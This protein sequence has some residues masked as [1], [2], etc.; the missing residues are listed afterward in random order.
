[1]N[2]ILVFLAALILNIANYLPE[3]YPLTWLGMLPLIFVI[4]RLKNKAK[5]VGQ[6]KNKQLKNLDRNQNLPAYQDLPAFKLG[7]AF[8]FFMTAFSSIF[9]YYSIEEFTGFNFWLI[10]FILVMLYLL[11]GL[12]YGLWFKVYLKTAA[13]QFSA[14]Y[15]ALSWLV[16][17]FIRYKL[18][19]FYPAGY[20]A[21]TQTEF[22]HFIQLADLG[23]FWILSFLLA[24]VGGLLYQL[25]FKREFKKIIYLALIFLLIF[26]YGQLRLQQYSDLAP[27]Y[28]LGLIT[29]SISQDVKW[30]QSQRE[31]NNQLMLAAAEKLNQ[32]DLIIAPETNITFDFGRGGSASERLLQEIET[33]FDTPLQF[34]T[35]ATFNDSANKYN[36]SFLISPQGELQQRYNKNLLL[37]FGEKYPAEALINKVLPYHFSSL[38]NGSEIVIFSLE[39]VSWKNA[40]CSEILYT[41]YLLQ[42]TDK[43]DFIVNQTNE[44]WFQDSTLLKNLMFSSAVIRAVENRKTVV[45]IGN[46]AIDAVITAAGSYELLPEA[47]IYQSRKINLSS[48]KTFYSRLYPALELLLWALTALFFINYFKK[49]RNY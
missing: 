49:I 17:E 42:Q 7:W 28:S 1:M 11:I 22:S 46:L 38:A 12:I 16:L 18:L 45:K 20:L 31:K 39:D 47:E 15:F 30:D 34:G 43:A 24:L 29:T 10:V 21:V 35:L 37:Y 25:V 5:A 6:T 48:Q 41:D 14:L 2:F 27:D 23:G 9:V 40:I 33:R 26:G 3:L 13:A 36:S 44:A 32:N 4:E 19:F 8:G